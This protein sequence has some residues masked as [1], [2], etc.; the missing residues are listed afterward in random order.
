MEKGKAPPFE[1]GRRRRRQIEL[2]YAY[3]TMATHKHTDEL[4]DCKALR[5]AKVSSRKQAWKLCS[6][7]LHEDEIKAHSGQEIGPINK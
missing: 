3:N 1:K 7:L 2:R 4:F 5:K 6:P